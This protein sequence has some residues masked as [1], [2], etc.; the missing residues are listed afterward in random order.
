MRQSRDMRFAVVYLTFFL[1]TAGTS[2]GAN[3]TVETFSGGAQGWVGSSFFSGIWA[4]T[5]GVAR[6]R[7][8]NQGEIAFPETG[9]LSNSPSASSGSFTGNYDAANISVIGFRFMAPHVVPSGLVIL[10]W[11]GS[12]SVYQQGFV[13]NATGVWFTCTASIAD[14]AVA[15]WSPTEGSLD[16]FAA[17]RQSVKFVSVRMT[18]TGTQSQDYLLDDIYLAGQPSVGMIS[19]SNGTNFT[20]ASD[21]L[22]S[23]LYYEVQGAPAVTGAWQTIQTWLATNQS[24]IVILTNDA[25]QHFWRLSIAG[26]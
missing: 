8:P 22:V 2:R 20:F 13:V 24:Q 1:V 4:F 21:D 6:V 3:T 11:G 7:F 10:E 25:P 17:A 23:N 18:R 19:T 14:D 26:P 12:T 5:G 16:D 9:T 15:F